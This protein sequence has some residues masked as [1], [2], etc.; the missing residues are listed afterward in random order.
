M[1]GN[2]IYIGRTHYKGDLIPCCVIPRQKIVTMLNNEEVDIP[3][4][5]VLCGEVCRWV[6]CCGPRLPY[7]TLVVGKTENGEVLIIVRESCSRGFTSWRVRIIGN[8]I[9][10]LY[11]TCRR[12]LHQYEILT[13]VK[14]KPCV[15]M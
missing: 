5:E 9:R 14:C 15:V 3:E 12:P 13:L 1:D 6:K 11:D 4:Y 7:R 10:I 8:T 2:K